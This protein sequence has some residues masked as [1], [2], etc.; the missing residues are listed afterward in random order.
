MKIAVTTTGDNLDAPLDAR[1]GRA[2]SFLIFD[3]ETETFLIMP[4]AQ[5]MQAVQ[6]A[7]VQSGQSVAG[8]GAEALITGHVG[9]KAYAVLQA[10]GVKVYLADLPTVR[11]AIAAWRDGRLNATD[12]ADRSGHWS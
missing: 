10:A 4:N 11:E 8:S 12:G 5:N 9:P 7:G 1:F 3:T 2:A 6:G